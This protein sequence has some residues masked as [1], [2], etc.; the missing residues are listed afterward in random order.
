MMKRL[1]TRVLAI[2]CISSL[3]VLSVACSSS[4]P[5]PDEQI[6]EDDLQAEEQ[7]VVIYN[8]RFNPNSVDLP[9]GSTVIFENQDPEAHNINIPALNVDQNLQPGQTWE[10]TL[11]TVGDFAV[12]NRFSD[13]MMLDLYVRD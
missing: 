3:L 11:D 12:G 6:T 4:E 7:R 8:F 10:L 2:S 1:I 13:G 9:L 5:V